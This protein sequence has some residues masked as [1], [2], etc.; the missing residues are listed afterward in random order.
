MKKMIITILTACVL[1]ASFIT[2]SFLEVNA[3]GFPPITVTDAGEPAANGLYT[4]RGQ[5]HGKPYYTRAD[6]PSSTVYGAIAW[7]PQ[8]GW[9]INKIDGDTYYDTGY[10]L[11]PTHADSPDLV[12]EWFMNI[13]ELPV[14]VTA[15]N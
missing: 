8:S 1:F 9:Y 7:S 4:Y 2:P 3:V 15:C 13:A 5:S 6:L 10:P 14:T 12:K 11:P